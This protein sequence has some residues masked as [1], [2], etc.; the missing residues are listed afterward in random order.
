MYLQPLSALCIAKLVDDGLIKWDDEV[1]KFW[2]EYAQNGKKHTT[3]DHVLAHQV[4][5][6]YSVWMNVL[7]WLY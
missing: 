1:S 6:C 7:K 4:R 5:F 3:I 2:R